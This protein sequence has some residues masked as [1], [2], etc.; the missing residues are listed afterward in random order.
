MNLDIIYPKSCQ[1]MPELPDETIDCTLTS[2]PY[3]GLRDYG[4]DVKEIWGGDP[5]CQHEWGDKVLAPKGEHHYGQGSS[6]LRGGNVSPDEDW[7]K[8]TSGRKLP[9]QFCQKCNAWHGQLGLEP[10]FQLY[11][12]HMMIVCAEIKRVMKKTGSLW[13]NL[14]DTYGGSVERVETIML[15]D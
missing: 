14:G 9:S 3:Y 13:L 7:N 10:T 4:E 8:E 5:D 15:V 1:K 2:P 12:D 11:L 6:T